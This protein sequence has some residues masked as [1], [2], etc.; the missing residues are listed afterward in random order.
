MV[1]TVP[2]RLGDVEVLVETSPVAGPEPTSATSDAA[3]RVLDVFV[4][5]RDTIVELAGSMSDVIAQTATRGVRPDQL[6][7]EFGLKVSAKGNIIVAG[8][9]GEATLRVKLTYDAARASVAAPARR[10]ATASP[11]AEP[12]G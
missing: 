4:S 10:S 2:V 1:K 5:A 3:E 7:V 11:H 9:S 8:A 6:E 12:T